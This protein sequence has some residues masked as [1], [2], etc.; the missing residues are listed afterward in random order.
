MY[1][2]HHYKTTKQRTISI[3]LVKSD[4]RIWVAVLLTGITIFGISS[5][6]NAH[7]GKN[8]GD[9]QITSFAALQAATDLYSRLIAHGKLDQTWETQL[10]QVKIGAPE[11]N[12][13]PNYT[14]TFTRSTGNPSGVLFIIAPNGEYVGSDFV[15]SK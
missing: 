14:V 10:A 5:I 9:D 6:A 7:G 13:Q 3:S 1:N 12:E 11:Q 4:L 15:K 2:A 8:H